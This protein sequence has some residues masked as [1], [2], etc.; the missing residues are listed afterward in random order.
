[1]AAYNK[2]EQFVEDLGSGVHILTAAGG[3]L[4]VYLSNAAPSASA[5]AVK[6]DL[7]EITNEN[8]Y[9]APVDTVNTFSQTGGI[10]ICGCT[11]SIEILAAGGTVGPFQYVVLQNT[12]PTS[13]LDPL[14]AWW[15]HG[16]AVTLADGESFTINFAGSELFR[17]T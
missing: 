9:T 14:I 4:E 1:M 11:P 15:D 2:F 7:A 8:G 10:G 17:I 5:D 13:P 6:A 3:V 12:T 16:S